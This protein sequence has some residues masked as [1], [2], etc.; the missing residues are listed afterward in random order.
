MNEEELNKRLNAYYLHKTLPKESLVHLKKMIE[1]DHPETS[2][3]VSIPNTL[4]A[5]SNK[6]CN[7]CDG[8]A[9]FLFAKSAIVLMFC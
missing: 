9:T 7:R 1:Q 8:I 5:S 4:N 2:I 6:S 3:L